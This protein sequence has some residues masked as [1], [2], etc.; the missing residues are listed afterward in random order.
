MRLRASPSLILG[1]VLLLTAGGVHAQDQEPPSPS[2]YQLKAAFLFNFAKF[3]EWPPEAF[4]D[5]KSPFIIGVLGDNPFGK[6]L[7]RTV[8]GKIV[9]GR[10]IQ[11]REA[12]S[13]AEAK[14]CHILFVCNSEN[15]RLQEVFEAL[16]GASVLTVG[17]WTHF[18][19]SGGMISFVLENSKIRFQINDQAAR[20]AGLKISSKL[21]NL[22]LRP[23]R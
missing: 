19:E 16:R 7:E 20:A 2:E 4:A 22:A 14:K 6:E 3:V 18:T 1:L 9:N 8:E 11:I 10:Y 15:K 17:D 12:G 13:L 5:E 21:L 23:P